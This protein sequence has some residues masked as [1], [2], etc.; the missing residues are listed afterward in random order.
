[1]NKEGLIGNDSD[2]AQPQVAKKVCKL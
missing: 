1:M 2:V